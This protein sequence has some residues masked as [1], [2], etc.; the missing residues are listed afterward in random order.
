M[1][2]LCMC[3]HTTPV[4]LGLSEKLLILFQFGFTGPFMQCRQTETVE[5][6]DVDTL[7]D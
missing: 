7:V 2:F 6:D 5:S 4:F 1:I 3:V